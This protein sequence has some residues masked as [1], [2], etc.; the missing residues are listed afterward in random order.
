MTITFDFI[1]KP[2]EIASRI[3][4]FLLSTGNHKTGN[5]ESFKT[6]ELS[7]K[8]K[9]TPEETN[10]AIDELESLGLVKTLNYQGTYPFSH[11]H[12][13]ATYFLFLHFKDRITDYDPEDD[14]RKVASAIV[15]EEKKE[16]EIDGSILKEITDL[17]PLRINR[18]VAYLNYYSLIDVIKALGTAPY[19]FKLINATGSTRRFVSENCNR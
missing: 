8:L 15:I 10:D 18:A 6:E 9:L 4:L 12:V 19:D 5:E 16:K 11:G 13:E 2:S 14:I 7:E 3:G 17:S 1:N